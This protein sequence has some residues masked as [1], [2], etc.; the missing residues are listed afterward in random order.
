MSAEMISSII[1]LF[2]KPRPCLIPKELNRNIHLP[3]KI[4]DFA[5][6]YTIENTGLSTGKLIEKPEIT[7]CNM[8]GTVLLCELDNLIDCD[9]LPKQAVT[10]KVEFRKICTNQ[11]AMVKTNDE[12]EITITIWYKRPWW[13]EKHT[14]V[15][16][17]SLEDEKGNFKMIHSKAT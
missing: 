6:T 9:I 14:T 12:I 11:A 7:I 4:E 17:F 8:D 15:Q 10:R 2:W 5:L 3:G 1:A 13:F 16:K